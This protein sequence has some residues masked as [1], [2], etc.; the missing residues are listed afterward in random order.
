M[1]GV[2]DIDESFQ[3]LGGLSAA[4]QSLSGNAPSEYI[5]DLRQP[6][7]AKTVKLQN[8]LNAEMD[9]RLLN[10]EWLARMMKENYAG[11]ALLSRM[12]DNLWGWQATSP[13][14]VTEQLWSKTHQVLMEDS[15]GLGMR[16]F[17]TQER[18]WAYQSIAA[19][20]LEATRKGFWTPGEDVRKEL[21]AGYLQSVLRA[22]MAC[23]DHT[24]N[25]PMLNQ[26][27]VQLVSIPGGLPSDVVQQ[28][29][30]TVEKAIGRTLDDA[31]KVQREVKQQLAQGF[32]SKP[33]PSAQQETEAK[34]T[35]SEQ[36]KSQD[37]EAVP[38][39]GFKLT[40]QTQSQ[41]DAQIPAS[42]L[43]WKILLAIIAIIAVIGIGVIRSK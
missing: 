8:F 41:D 35:R 4:V 34:E 42:G 9:S 25:N 17:L 24:C 14:L 15:H 16:E 12:V 23:C 33:Q 3:Y 37:A 22:G 39:K 29:R 11:A 7:R 2:T 20:L 28:F 38:V 5:A 10:R 21:A 18:E 6:N 26:M 40:Q 32:S 36:A 1:Y 30:L 31:E 27:V 43:E 13:H 19:R